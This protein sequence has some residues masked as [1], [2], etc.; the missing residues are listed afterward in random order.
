ML[1]HSV[2]HSPQNF[3]DIICC[4]QRNPLRY[5]ASKQCKIWL[6]T[7]KV[8]IQ[9]IFVLIITPFCNFINRWPSVRRLNSF[10]KSTHC[11]A[12]RLL[13]NN[14][15]KWPRYSY[16]RK[17]SCTRFQTTLTTARS[18]RKQNTFTLTGTCM[19]LLN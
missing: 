7:T 11:W 12:R 8:I 3:R 4:T 14:N 18:C 13:S 9:I 15:C 17:M 6:F 5:T 19:S 2:I 1:R 16:T 10:L